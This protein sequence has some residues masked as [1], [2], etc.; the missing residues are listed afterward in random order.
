VTAKCGGDNDRWLE[1]SLLDVS[2]DASTAEGEGS[3]TVPHSTILS[4]R[5]IRASC[6]LYG[7]GTESSSGSIGRN[8]DALAGPQ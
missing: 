4:P 1:L 3:G 6:A 7:S 5:S 8:S 2:S